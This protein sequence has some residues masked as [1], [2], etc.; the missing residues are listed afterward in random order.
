MMC[1]GHTEQH[2]TPIGMSP[3]HLVFGKAYYLLVDLEHRAYWAIKTFNFDLDQAGKRRKFELS[4]LEELR[5]DAYES[6]RIAKERMKAFHDKRIHRKIFKTEDQVWIY[7][8]RLHMFPGKLQSRWYGPGVVRKMYQSGTVRVR[9]EK[10]NLTI[11]GQRL[12]PYIDG[13]SEPSPEEEINLIDIT[14]F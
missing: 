1:C 4:E 7:N 12:K 9:Y 3:Y 14:E 6:S 5:D 11:N 13:E 2:S 10:S 8:S